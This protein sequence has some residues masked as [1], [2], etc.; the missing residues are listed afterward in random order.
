MLII[1]CGEEATETILDKQ[2]AR[3]FFTRENH[4]LRMRGDGFRAA[5]DR[6]LVFNRVGFVG[7]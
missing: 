6:P 5:T 2:V 3:A 7:L 1:R 4:P